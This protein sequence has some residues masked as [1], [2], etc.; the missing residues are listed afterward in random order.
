[1]GST[2]SGRTKV[3][4]D[5]EFVLGYFSKFS[6][7]IHILFQESV[8]TQHRPHSMNLITLLG[9]ILLAALIAI[10]GT[11]SGAWIGETLLG[12]DK[13]P[14]SAIMLSILIGILIG[15]TT[16][17]THTFKYGIQ[18]CLK[19]ILRLGIKIGRAHV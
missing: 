14:I 6:I 10:T 1:M 5:K 16:N 15:N 13:S 2:P 3:D 8:L 4:K 19:R 7:K 17:A 9:G 12:F 11:F 18:F